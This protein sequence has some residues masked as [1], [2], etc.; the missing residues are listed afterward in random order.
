MNV[1]YL[2]PILESVSN[3][4]STMA[5]MQV[6]PGKPSLKNQYVALG[7]VTGIITMQS[8][9]LCGSMAIS[10]KKKVILKIYEKMIGEKVTDI[11][12]SV[13]DLVGELTNMAC[14]GAK[15]RLA[16]A[17][18]DFSMSTPSIMTGNNHQ[19]IHKYNGP[20]ILLPF[21][22]EAGVFFVEMCFEPIDRK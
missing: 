17:G 20:L 21:E 13:K 14:G 18:Y 4:L 19:I 6:K 16:N 22:T 11:N 9:T 7:D 3:V 12:E 2:N 5:S 1:E 15:V 10:F 8:E